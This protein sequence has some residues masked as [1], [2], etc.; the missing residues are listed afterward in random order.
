MPSWMK[1]VFLRKLPAVLKMERPNNDEYYATDE[2]N[3]DCS[4]EPV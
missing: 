4:G 3:A 2:Q 1:S